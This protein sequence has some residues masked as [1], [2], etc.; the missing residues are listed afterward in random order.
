MFKKIHGSDKERKLDFN[1]SRNVQ[2]DEYKV[3]T[4]AKHTDKSTNRQSISL[5]KR[6]KTATSTITL[7]GRKIYTCTRPHSPWKI[8]SMMNFG[9]YSTSF[10]RDGKS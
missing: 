8:A 3:L 10:S 1:H 9:I 7:F 2:N 4:G 6:R 5:F